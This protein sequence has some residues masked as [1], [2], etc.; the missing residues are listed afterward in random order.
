M[1]QAC[2]LACIYTAENALYLQ[3][4]F[5]SEVFRGVPLNLIAC[6]SINIY[7]MRYILN[8]FQLFLSDI[9]YFSV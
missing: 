5:V 3:L 4:V 7:S 2:R 1:N 9:N 8:K 6:L